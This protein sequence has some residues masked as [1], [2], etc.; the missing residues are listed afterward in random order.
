[1]SDYSEDSPGVAGL[2][3]LGRNAI[4]RVTELERALA[5]RD[6]TIR[7]L[8]DPVVVHVAMLRGDIAVPPLAE[9]LHI[10][11]ATFSEL[12]AANIELAKA[13]ETIRQLTERT[14]AA[15]HQ[16]RN[17]ALIIDALGKRA[18]AAERELQAV[19][20]APVVAWLATQQQRNPSQCVVTTRLDGWDHVELIARPTR[21]GE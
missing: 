14:D 21:K 4:E 11:G 15:E 17:Y 7:K 12:D 6:E 16:N 1:M 2:A 8:R 3:Q 5:E 10:Y 20:D 18:E 19:R 13:R 9:M